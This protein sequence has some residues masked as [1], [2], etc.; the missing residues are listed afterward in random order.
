MEIFMCSVGKGDWRL[1]KHEAAKVWK[2]YSGFS[3]FTGKGVEQE[4][5]DFSQSSA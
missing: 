5:G 2:V 3:R 4:K 1:R